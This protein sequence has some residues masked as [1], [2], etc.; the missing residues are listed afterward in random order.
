MTIGRPEAAVDRAAATI[1]RSA[2]PPALRSIAIGPVRIP[3]IDRQQQQLALQHWRRVPEHYRKD[4]G[5]PGR[6]VLHR[7]D[8]AT[9]RDAIKTS[10]FVVQTHDDLEQTEHARCP[11]PPEAHRHRARRQQQRQADN[12]EDRGPCEDGKIK[13]ERPHPT[14]RHISAC[15]VPTSVGCSHSISGRNRA[16]RYFMYS[17]TSKAVVPRHAHQCSCLTCPG[18]TGWVTMS[19][20]GIARWNSKRLRGM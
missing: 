19:I 10:D 18:K 13:G 15:I 12:T 7:N 16:A 17:A 2:A 4:Q 5:V 14:H 8:A 6:L 3:A 11:K 20:S 1:R 9:P